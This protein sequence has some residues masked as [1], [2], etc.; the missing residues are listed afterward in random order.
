M[1]FFRI[2]R[3]LPFRKILFVAQRVFSSC[4]KFYG[5][6]SS[7]S[8]HAEN[9]MLRPA[10]FLLVR[11]I[12]RLAQ[13]VFCSCEKFHALPSAFSARAENFTLCPMRFPVM[14]LFHCFASAFP[15]F[16]KISFHTR[17]V[18]S[19]LSCTDAC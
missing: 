17:R 18:F 12:S 3:I 15:H 10:R 8:S 6:P 4:G 14:K 1:F 19:N 11:K 7:F 2:F 16:A 9:F 13:H 5:L